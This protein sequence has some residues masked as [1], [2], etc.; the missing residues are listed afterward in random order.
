MMDSIGLLAQNGDHA[1]ISF[2]GTETYA[3]LP[4]EAYEGEFL[5]TPQ[6]LPPIT[7]GEN[8]K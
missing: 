7:L 8:V 6:I 5:C 1:E 2:I 3:W 4:D